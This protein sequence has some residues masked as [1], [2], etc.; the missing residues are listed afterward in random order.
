MMQKALPLPN[1]SL[2]LGKHTFSL[3]SQLQVDGFLNYWVEETVAP[4]D[5]AVNTG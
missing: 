5:K 1:F 4:L 3:K 2:V